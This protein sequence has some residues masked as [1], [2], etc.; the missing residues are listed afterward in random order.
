MALER[1]QRQDQNRPIRVSEEK[2]RLD[3][4]TG[5]QYA[6]YANVPG[7][8]EPPPAPPE[9]NSSYDTYMQHQQR[10]DPSAN[11][12]RPASYNQY[13]QDFP[14]PPTSLN[15]NVINNPSTSLPSAMK[16]AQEPPP[17]AKKSVS[18][19]TQMNTYKDRTPSQSVSSYKSPPGSQSSD[20][21]MAP[22]NYN[23]LETDVF[24]PN[25]PHPPPAGTSNAAVSPA[26]K[27]VVYNTSGGTPN[28]IG[29]QEVYRDPR[30]RI[31]AK[32][33]SQTTNKTPGSERMSFRDKM[34]YFA[35]EAGEEPVKVK[36][37]ASKTLR[38][39][40]TQLHYSGH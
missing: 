31:E 36:P 3:S 16:N 21:G 12:Q 35:Q 40:E 6:Q 10:A 33:A 7:Q 28:V 25:H 24:E 19:N 18:F 23:A 11:S 13:N 1:Q 38:D 39:I 22:N 30:S 34:K 17:P 9:R 8:N 27:D 14:P 26:N 29:S 2:R 20:L 4:M 37:K 32:I 5:G 15:N